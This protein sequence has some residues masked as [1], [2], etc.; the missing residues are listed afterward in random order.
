MLP[1]A[2]ENI[3]GDYKDRME[4][5]EKFK[6]V[7]AEIKS[8]L[9]ETCHFPSGCCSYIEILPYGTMKTSFNLTGNMT[10]VGIAGNTMDIQKYTKYYY[11]F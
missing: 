10:A 2:V 3:I 9:H 4:H 1:V 5:Y 8:I 7:L 11:R 6:H